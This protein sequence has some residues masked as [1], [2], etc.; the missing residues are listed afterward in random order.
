MPSASGQL[1]AQIQS[2]AP[3]PRHIGQT[4]VLKIDIPPQV[5]E[6]TVSTDF[7]LRLRFAEEPPDRSN[8]MQA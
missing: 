2:A 4:E 5:C 3:E 8:N 7:Q 1:T 6:E